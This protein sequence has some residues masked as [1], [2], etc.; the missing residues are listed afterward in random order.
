MKTAKKKPWSSLPRSQ[1]SL[2]PGFVTRHPSVSH[3]THSVIYQFVYH[4]NYR[5]FILVHKEWSRFPRLPAGFSSGHILDQNLKQND[6]LDFF[7]VDVEGLDLEVLKTND[8]NKYRPKVV[9]VESNMSIKQEFDS[10]LAQY[11]ELQNY[12]LIGKSNIND[13]LGNLFF[14]SNK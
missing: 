7:D 1:P 14:V 12:K 11:L 9:V 5:L 13:D 3:C 8:W 2:Q 6:R 10:E 4:L